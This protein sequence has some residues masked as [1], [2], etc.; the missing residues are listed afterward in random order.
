V[1]TA[2]A[3]A[4]PALRAAAA[5]LIDEAARACVPRSTEIPD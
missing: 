3:P 2:P 5:A 1:S 4:E